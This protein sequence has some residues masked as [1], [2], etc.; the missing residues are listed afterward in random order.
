[1]NSICQNVFSKSFFVSP[2]RLPV[3]WPRFLIPPVEP[4]LMIFVT[5]SIYSS[6]DFFLSERVGCWG[7]I[8]L[9]SNKEL[10]LAG[11]GLLL[12]LLGPRNEPV[13][14]FQQRHP[15]F[16]LGLSLRGL[17]RLSGDP[18]GDFICGANSPM[19]SGVSPG[20]VWNF[21]CR[22]LW[23]LISSTRRAFPR[24]VNF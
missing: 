11:M 4:S 15:V 18:M 3:I 19:S 24:S 8:F 9:R 20:W 12:E 5:V 2:L 7:V 1:M 22:P 21:P 13:H 14:F 23:A 17:T 16:F 6:L 10:G